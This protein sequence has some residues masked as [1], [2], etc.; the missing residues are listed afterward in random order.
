MGPTLPAE[1]VGSDE[2][3]A[4]AISVVPMPGGPELV[5]VPAHADAAVIVT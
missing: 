5:V 4:A 1:P 3:T 2:A